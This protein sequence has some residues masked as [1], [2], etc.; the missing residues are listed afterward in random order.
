M[1]KSVVAF[2]LLY[3]ALFANPAPAADAPPPNGPLDWPA[4]THTMRPWCYWWW[5]GSAVNKADLTRELETYHDAG[6]GGVHIIPIYGA[7]GYER[8]FINYLSPEWMDMLRHVGTET[9]RLDMGFDMTTGTGWCFGGPNVSEREAAAV[10][11]PKTYDL[12][13]GDELPDKVG[14]GK[15][16]ALQA[17]VAYSDRGDVIDLTDRIKDDGRVDWKA[18]AGKWKVYAVSEIPSRRQPKVKRAAPGG[19]GYMLNPLYEPA[20]SHYLKRFTEAFAGYDGPK[21]RAMYHDSFEYDVNWSPDFFDQFQRRRGYRLQDEL[22]ALFGDA[23]ADRSARVKC[24]YRETVSDLILD[25]FA[26]IWVRWSHEQGF[27]TRNEAH[28]S[29]ANLLDLYAAADVPETEMFARHR[30]PLMAKFASSAAH[31]AGRPLVSSETGTWLNENFNETPGEMKRLADLLFVSGINHVFYHGTCYSPKSAEWPGWVFY[32]ATQMNPRNPIWHDVPAL[33]A[34]VARCQ[35]VLQ[36][37]RPDN[38]VMLY[39]PAYDVWHS[40]KGLADKLSVEQADGEN[41]WLMGSP[42]ARTAKGLWDRGFTFDYVSDRQLQAVKWADGSLEAPGGG[43]YRVVVVPPVEHM[44]L[45]AL[46]ALLRLAGDGATVVF[47]TRLPGDVPGW[48]VLD[49]RRGALRELVSQVKLE[50]GA[51]AKVRRAIVGNGRVL[52]G[53]VEAA[54]ADVRV[55]REALVDRSG[56]LFVRRSTAAGRHYF[57]THAGAE[58]VDGWVPLAA[59]AASVA[60][61]DPMTGRA[62]IA[63][64]RQAAAAGVEVYLQLS[65]GESVIL[66]TF[67][68]EKVDGPAWAYRK[69]A[70]D[71]VP[72]TG[73]WSVRFVA[74]GPGVPK[75]LLTNKLDSWTTLGGDDHKRFAGTAAY[76]VT[77]DAPAGGA[78]GGWALDLGRVCESARVRLN[79][80]DLGTLFGPSFRLDVGRLK[81]TGNDLEVE[82]TNVAAN[83]VRDLDRRGV[84]WKNFYDANVVNIDYKLFDAAEWPVRDAGLIGPV[85]LVPMAE[86]K[87]IERAD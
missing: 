2:A 65:P 32:A 5:M 35:S 60:L 75:P 48:G 30:N 20:V 38:D 27:I 80:R 56:L 84:K 46:R 31:V 8:E 19:E 82:V 36:S 7:K 57:V 49:E 10:A 29:P 4:V 68:R 72:L 17:V 16:E 53:D 13:A 71:P 37:G 25:S 73:E 69:P 33:N 3:T 54:L 52:A 58:P 22:P 45:P 76:T 70:G 74:G 28:G 14:R 39:W 77:F 61:L 1:T 62:G 6:V 18:P 81:A 64:K 55:S 87:P 23:A 51:D 50:G 24:D 9:R 86:L 42:F 83:R 47:D 67:A 79:G 11:A 43:A 40:P 34:Y 63:A 85:R 44:P 12:S 78:D 21:P 41:G 26:A 15:G 66:R 59:D